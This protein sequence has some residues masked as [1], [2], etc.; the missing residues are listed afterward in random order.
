[1]LGHPRMILKLYILMGNLGLH[2]HVLIG[3]FGHGW[4][5]STTTLFSNVFRAS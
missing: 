1:M 4:I 5:T 3:V 2:G